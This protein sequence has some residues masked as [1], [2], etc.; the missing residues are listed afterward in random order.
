[1]PPESNQ[2]DAIGCAAAARRLRVV[3]WNCHGAVGRDFRCRPERVLAVIS[4]LQPD[5]L[6]LQEVDG[7]A[8]LGRRE[9]AF[10]WFTERLGP[11]ICEARTV[12]RANHD[13][14]H[15]LWSR[16]PFHSCETS[17]LPGKGLEPR[18]AI[19]VEIE[20]PGGSITVLAAHLGLSP[21]ARE[22]QAEFLAARAAASSHPTLMLGDTNAWRLS[23]PVDD[24]LRT[25]LPVAAS[26]KSFP[27]WW[28]LA[29]MDRIY[30]GK[31]W[32]LE[33]CFAE[34]DAARISDHL[35]VVADF[36]LSV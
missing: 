31:G 1:M 10:E 19:A 9:R 32:V 13:Y 25:V 12:P 3:T 30:A 34:T 7:R 14:G 33:R 22:R 16:W 29:R 11:H 23:G 18:M 15:L 21:F 26:A 20:T 17:T 27:A 24:A 6:A 36:R 4:R 8:H 2:D 5:I 28:P 35:P